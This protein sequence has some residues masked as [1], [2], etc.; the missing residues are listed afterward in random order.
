MQRSPEKKSEPAVGAVK[1][2]D[3]ESVKTA[4]VQDDGQPRTGKKKKRNRRHGHRKPGEN[5]PTQ[6]GKPVSD[7]NRSEP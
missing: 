7:S 3:S 4:Q 1:Q 2:Q 6:Q 5:T